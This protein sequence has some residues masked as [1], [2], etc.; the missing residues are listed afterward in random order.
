MNAM[1]L[2]CEAIH[3]YRELEAWFTEITAADDT[4]AFLTNVGCDP[5]SGNGQAV[6]DLLAKEISAWAGYVKLAK[7]EPI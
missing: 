3:R 7:I 2:E 1:N 6:K 4:R 5:F